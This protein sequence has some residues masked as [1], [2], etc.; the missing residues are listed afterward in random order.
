MILKM[1][2]D[3]ICLMFAYLPAYFT[4]LTFINAS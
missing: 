4:F 3:I 2:K 1:N